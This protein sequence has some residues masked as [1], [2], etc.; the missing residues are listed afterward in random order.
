MLKKHVRERNIKFP[1]YLIQFGVYST[2]NELNRIE[3]FPNAQIKVT[4]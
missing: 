2:V 1:R 3:L 4:L